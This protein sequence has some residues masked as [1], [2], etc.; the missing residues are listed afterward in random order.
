M[1][2]KKTVYRFK[3]I[4][5]YLACCLS[6]I[7]G[8]SGV[9]RRPVRNVKRNRRLA[10]HDVKPESSKK[11]VKPVPVQKTEKEIAQCNALRLRNL[12]KLPKA[13]KWVCYE[14][15]YSTLDQ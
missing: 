4:A 8:S 11:Q 5:T 13:H 15:F 14:W 12:L 2:P 1:V 7:G 3:M 6:L 9:R 10:N